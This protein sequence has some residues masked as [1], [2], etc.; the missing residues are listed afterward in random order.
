MSFTSGPATT[1][2]QWVTSPTSP[3]MSWERS[4]TPGASDGTHGRWK[5]DAGSGSPHCFAP[6]RGGQGPASGLRRPLARIDRHHPASGGGVGS[7]GR[8]AHRCWHPAASP[9][10]RQIGA[11]DLVSRVLTYS[12]C[13]PI[14]LRAERGSCAVLTRGRRGG[15]ALALVRWWPR[16]ARTSNWWHDAP[17]R[18]RPPP[19]R[20][21]VAPA[22]TTGWP[23]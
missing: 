4:S 19:H 15:A 5:E 2:G 16:S 1:A 11:P 23:G 6:L 8:Q 18:R 20:F 21:R 12:N 22:G 10:R 7:V 9:G 3:F 13:T 14:L 17:R